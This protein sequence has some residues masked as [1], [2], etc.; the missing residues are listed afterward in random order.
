M[1]VAENTDDGEVIGALS[2]TDA[3]NDTITYSITSD[4]DD[5]FDING[6]N[7][8]VDGSLDFET[9]QSHSVTVEASDGNGG[10]ASS[11]FT[12]NVTDVDET[13]SNVSPTNLSLDANTVEEDAAVATVVGKLSATDPDGPDANIIYSLS[14][15]AGN[16]FAIQGSNI[17]VNGELDFESNESHTVT[18]D[19]TDGDGGVTSATFTI[20]V[21]DVDEGSSGGEATQGP[22]IFTG[23]SAADVFDGLSGADIIKGKG[24]DD[25]LRGSAGADRVVGNNGDDLLYGGGGR[26]TVKG[27]GGADKAYGDGGKDN[28][29]GG[30]GNDKVYGGNGK[31]I[32]KGQGGSDDIYGGKGRDTLTGGGAEDTFYFNDNG[33]SGKDTITDFN[34]SQD[35]IDL[36]DE[37][38]S[39]SDLKIRFN[40][41]DAK[42]VTDK[43]EYIVLED[44]A[45]ADVSADIFDFG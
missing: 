16:R 40:S 7:L 42:I 2:S 27:G 43:G 31:D 29:K 25:E 18:V 28:V 33:K 34:I 5:K 21:T 17:V 32:V 10:T 14:S 11:T 12:V 1:S 41:G 35:M 37:G 6:S 23:T 3:E 38:L 9:K 8:I 20:N 22:D 30:A 4:S 24:G 36:S 19:A 39:F 26:D 13:S 45:K 44:V 15:D